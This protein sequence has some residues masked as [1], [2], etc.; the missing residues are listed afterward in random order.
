M[1]KQLLIFILSL[2]ILTM[3][4]TI[5]NIKSLDFSDMARPDQT[6]PEVIIFEEDFENG[7][8]DWTTQDG[9]VPSG[10]EE[11]WSIS[12]EDAYDGNSW[13][14][15]ADAYDGYTDHRYIVLD[16]PEITLPTTG[17][18]SLT[19]MMDYAM[20]GIGGTG[21]YNGWDG[22]NVRI[23]TDNGTT[24]Q[25]LENPTESYDATSFFAFGQIFHEGPGIAAWGGVLGG[26]TETSFDLDAF[27]GNNVVI[28]FAFASDNAICTNDDGGDNSWFGVRIDDVNIASTFSTDADGATGD[29]QMVNA[30]GGTLSGDFWQIST[31][32]AASGS[33]SVHCSIEPYLLDDI[34]SPVYDLP[35]IEDIYLGY[36][37]YCDMQDADGN[38][39]NYLEDMYEVSVKGVDETDWTRL[40]YAYTGILETDWTY[41]NQEFALN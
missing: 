10:W 23:S 12:S 41:V 33:Q 17:D 1:K 36:Y 3:F 28:R 32:T 7:I 15:H 22:F 14:M 39:D 24:W 5:T 21:D 30:Y 8:G 20:E 11:S 13:W 27:A 6:R 19:F 34:I 37:V 18:L 9:T 40:H 31:T 4:A 35:D 38:D 25:V 26:W 29:N 2:T 16:T